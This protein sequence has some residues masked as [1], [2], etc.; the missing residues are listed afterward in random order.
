METAYS[1]AP[2]AGQTDF[3]KPIAFY[4]EA[5]TRIARPGECCTETWLV[6]CAFD[7]KKEVEAFKSYYSPKSSDFLL[8]A[9]ISQDVTRDY[10]CFVPDLGKYEGIYTDEMLMKRWG[11]TKDEFEFIES[12][13]RDV[14]EENGSGNSDEE[15]ADD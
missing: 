2:I 5:N 10:F 11:I 14:D 1:R 9:V 13:I 12:R 15:A 4:Y 6:A 3:S 7:T 8:Q